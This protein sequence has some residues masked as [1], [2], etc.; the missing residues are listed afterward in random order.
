MSTLRV[1]V[2]DD[3]PLI[4]AD[5]A[6]LL[7]AEP[8]VDVVGQGRHGLEALDL[9]QEHR[10]DALF[11][12]I[13]MPGLDGLGVVAELDPATAPSVVFVTAFD[14]Y[15]VSAFD[16]QAVDYLL[17]PFD[18]ARL[19]RAV[20]RVR[21]RRAASG[22]PDLERVVAALMTQR[23]ATPA[24]LERLAVR[25]VGRTL[26]VEVGAIRWIEASDNYVRLHTAEGAHLSRRTMRDLEELLDPQRF[27]RIHRST[28]VA[29]AE[30]Q[31]IRPLGDGDHQVVLRD[32][33]RL[34]LTRSYREAFEARFG[35]IA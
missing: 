20:E 1:V 26:L 16:A 22:P 5:L 7:G 10:P 4:L 13:R 29:L 19:R 28:I 6:K 11:L 12:D 33:T 34:V 3:E 14:Q 9:V 23:G 8:G 2:V 17:K 21:A 27:A 24:W 31:E 25:G 15:A 18:P 32:G 30:V 35:G